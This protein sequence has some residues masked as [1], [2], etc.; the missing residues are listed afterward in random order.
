MHCKI[1]MQY[2]FDKVTPP[3]K[4]VRSKKNVSA[5]SNFKVNWI[6]FLTSRLSRAV[7]NTQKINFFAYLKWVLIGNELWDL[8][9]FTFMYCSLRLI[10]EICIFTITYLCT[11]YSTHMLR[12]SPKTLKNPWIWIWQTRY[13]A[14]IW[15]WSLMPN[16]IFVSTNGLSFEKFVAFS[17]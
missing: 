10:V 17:I 13:P 5:S 2:S 8:A 16:G 7:Q 12:R 1:C 6:Y 15:N 11:K 3:C 9:A 14:S 4:K